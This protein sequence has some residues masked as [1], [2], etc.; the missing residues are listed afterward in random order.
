[1]A[2][3]TLLSNINTTEY[4]NQVYS[5]E[6]ESGAVERSDYGRNFGPIHDAIVAFVQPGDRVLDV[7]CGAGILCRRIKSAV[8]ASA[9][10]GI[11]FSDVTIARCRERDRGLGIEYECLSV[12]D[13][14]M[15]DR[16]FDLILLCEVIEHLDDAERAVQSAM[17]LLR[18]GG[19]FII[20]CPHDSEVPSHEH[21]R[22]WGHDEVFHLLADYGP[23]VTFLHF[24]PPRHSR[25][26]F[27]CVTK[28]PQPGT[29]EYYRSA[30]ELV[31]EKIATLTGKV[32]HT[33][34]SIAARGESIAALHSRHAKLRQMQANLV[35]KYD[36]LIEKGRTLLTT[37]ESMRSETAGLDREQAALNERIAKLKGEIEMHQQ[38][39]DA[40]RKTDQERNTEGTN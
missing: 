12:R 5:H 15:L 7:G 4:W 39:I 24:A 1:M 2:Q 34:R 35:R 10:T 31:E 22:V 36:L 29:V 6:W 21:V 30:I 19:R 13:V 32:D 18:D 37:I 3:E 17:S 9:V 28:T 26:L 16:E 20:T 14:G 11:D 27:A 23:S 8:P 40:M 25:W 33:N 38:A